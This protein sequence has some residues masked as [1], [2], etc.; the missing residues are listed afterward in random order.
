LD[1]TRKAGQ[2]GKQRKHG[3][4]AILAPEDLHSGF[5]K[6][7]EYF[8]QALPFNLKIF[9]TRKEA[10]TWLLSEYTVT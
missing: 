2:L 5:S 10:M 9:R 3:H 6:L 1:F 7:F 4:T 8:T